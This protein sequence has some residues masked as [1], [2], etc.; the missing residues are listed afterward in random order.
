MF[1][2][3]RA[4]HIAGIRH[5][6]RNNGS[7]YQSIGPDIFSYFYHLLSPSQGFPGGSAV[8]NLPAIQE[9]QET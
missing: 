4:W 2:I 3:L 1:G 6:C 5:D 9:S 8:K 7:I